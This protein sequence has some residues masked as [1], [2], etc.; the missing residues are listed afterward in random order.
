MRNCVGRLNQSHP[1]GSVLYLWSHVKARGIRPLPILWGSRDLLRYGSWLALTRPQGHNMAT[2][3]ANVALARSLPPR[4]QRFFAQNPP[5]S[6]IG[7]SHRPLK[8][9]TAN[10]SPRMPGAPIQGKLNPFQP[11]KNPRT[12]KWNPPIYSLRRQAE[13]VKL[14]AQHGVDDLL[15]GTIKSTEASMKRREEH[16]SRI[17]GTGLGQKVKG[18]VWERTLKSR[19][20]KRRQAMLE[21]PQMIQDW[22]QVR[23]HIQHA[24]FQIEWKRLTF[25]SAW[26]WSWMEEMASMNGCRHITGRNKERM[27]SLMTTTTIPY[28]QTG[29]HPRTILSTLPQPIGL[30]RREPALG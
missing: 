7:V 28:H 17:K 18:H 16:G 15:P 25:T 8:S 14:A 24:P 27:E 22:K 26:T 9:S 30:G 10:D 19:L 12:G 29:K 3:E 4:L 1:R 5:R 13:L 6:L 11:H 2:A 20:D 21:M 23:R